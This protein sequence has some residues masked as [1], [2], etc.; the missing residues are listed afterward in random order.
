[1]FY[2]ENNPIA[3]WTEQSNL[4]QMKIWFD[5]IRVRFARTQPIKVHTVVQFSAYHVSIR[6]III[7]TYL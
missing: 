1:M 3:L 6:S 2:S 7:Y 4:L 5:K